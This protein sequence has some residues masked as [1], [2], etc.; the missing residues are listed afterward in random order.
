MDYDLREINWRN[1]SKQERLK[2]CRQLADQ[3][4]NMSQFGAAAEWRRLAA[5]IEA[6]L[7][8]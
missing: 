1:V 4:E 3:A 7:S 8:A 5:R 2:R 6:M